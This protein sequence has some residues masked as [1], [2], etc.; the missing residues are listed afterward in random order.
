M[1]PQGHG[2]HQAQPLLRGDLQAPGAQ[3]VEEAQEDPG[4]VLCF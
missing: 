3:Q 1:Q 4:V 2:L